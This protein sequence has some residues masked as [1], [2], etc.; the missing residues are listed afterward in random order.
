MVL[1]GHS[2]GGLISKLQTVESSDAFWKT[3]S[4]H[5]FAEL[6]ADADIQRALASTFYFRPN[7]SIR[8]V[9]TLGTPHRGSPFSNNITRWAG[10]KLIAVP[11][12]MMDGRNQL[13]AENA[14]FFRANAPIDI[15][16]SIDSLSPDSPLLEPLLTATPGPWVTYHNVVGREPKPSWA[17]RY[18]VGEGDGVVALTSSRLDTEPQVESQIVVPSAHSYIHRHPQSVLE[19]RRVLFEQLTELQSFPVNYGDQV[20][21]RVESMDAPR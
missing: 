4:D 7:P 19:V 14:H 21:R 1:V 8:R 10:N 13:L 6:H 5:P 15:K 12:K 16:T 11:K 20:A 3:M 2:M 9:V 18:I 17:S